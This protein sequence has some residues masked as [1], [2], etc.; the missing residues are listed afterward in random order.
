MAAKIWRRY[1]LTL[2]ATAQP[3]PEEQ[4]AF[5]LFLRRIW[6]LVLRV[7]Y[8]HIGSWPRL[9]EMA[10]WPMINMLAWG[11][12]SVY[13]LKKLTHVEVISTTMVAGVLLLEFLIRM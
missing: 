9:L 7:A 5:P 4:G 8:L 6:A 1:F 12:T 10:Y 11:F 2:R 3:M 13:L